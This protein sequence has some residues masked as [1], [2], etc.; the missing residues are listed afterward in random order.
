MMRLRTLMLAVTLLA[1]PYVSA[2]QGADGAPSRAWITVGTA[3]VTTRGDCQT[4]EDDYPYRHSPS[5]LADVGYHLNRQADIGGEIFWVPVDTDQG[6]LRTTHFDAVAQFRPWRTRGFFLKGGAGMAF[7]RNWIDTLGTGSINSKAL[8]IVIGG[9]WAFRSDKRV[10]WQLFAT[11][12]AV[13]L[14]DLKTGDADVGDVMGNA[15]SLGAAIVF[16]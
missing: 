12:H 7:V 11:Q 1:V 3:W 15:W 9:G 8:S 16:R 5:V 6:Q 2:A 14:G 10:G 13:A 4:C